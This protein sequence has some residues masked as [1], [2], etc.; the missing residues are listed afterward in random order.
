MYA[1]DQSTLLFLMR[2]SNMC[3]LKKYKGTHGQ[4]AQGLKVQSFLE[5]LKMLVFREVTLSD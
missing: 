1:F 5:G 4:T 2:L 3:L